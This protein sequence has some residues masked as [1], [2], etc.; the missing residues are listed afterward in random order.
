M[1]SG[2]LPHLK[3][4]PHADSSMLI[5]FFKVGW[6]VAR[7]WYVT[8]P[9][10]LAILKSFWMQILEETAIESVCEVGSSGPFILSSLV[11]GSFALQ[12]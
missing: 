10:Y 6:G 1:P 4:T 2:S 11:S 8:C 12:T 9:S 7:S 3:Q 5:I